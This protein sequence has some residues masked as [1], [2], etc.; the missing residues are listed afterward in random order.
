MANINKKELDDLLKIEGKI[1]GVV[2]HT[3]ASYV[4]KKEGEK[5]LE[6]LKN[7]V[8]DLG[9]QINYDNPKKTDWYPIGLRAISL[10]LMKDTFGW[11]DKEIEEMGWNAPSFSFIIKIFMKFFVS[12]SK[13]AEESPRL[14]KEHYWDIGELVPE[15]HEDKKTLI[16]RLKNFKV[17]PI[18][19]IYLAGYFKRVASLG[20]KSKKI[21]CKETE[22]I[23]K[24]GSCDE[25]RITWE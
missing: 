8:K 17:H 10:I 13:I 4:L 7:I 25:F 15:L 1:R 23:F 12:I 22:C 3:D 14:W 2:F 6:R 11:S 19:C 18:I 24:E 5:G 16:L 9:Y 20:I 21:E